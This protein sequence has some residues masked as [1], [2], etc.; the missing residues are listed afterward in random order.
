MNIEPLFMRENLWQRE[1]KIS[2]VLLIMNKFDYFFLVYDDK[3]HYMD[4]IYFI[5]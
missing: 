4:F 2:R 5:E 3:V 1:N